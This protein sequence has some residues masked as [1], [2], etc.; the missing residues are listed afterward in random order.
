MSAFQPP[1]LETLLLYGSLVAALV[2][3]TDLGSYI[4]AKVKV[5]A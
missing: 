5:K 1:T 3:G 2:K 4:L